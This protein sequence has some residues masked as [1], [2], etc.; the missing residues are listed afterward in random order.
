M[1]GFNKMFVMVPVMLAARKLDSEDEQMVRMVRLTYGM[2]QA[3]CLLLV[4][5]VYLKAS[6]AAKDL[7]TDKIYVPQPAMVRAIL[8]S[9]FFYGEA[10]LPE[11]V[12]SPVFLSQQNINRPL[13]F[14]WF[15][16]VPALWR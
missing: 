8:P 7:P 11:F 3:V 10:S 15:A 5:Y 14:F 1:V 6:A 9:E 16:T 13:S 4:A 2:V 12:A